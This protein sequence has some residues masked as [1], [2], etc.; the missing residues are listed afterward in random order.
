MSDKTETNY[1]PSS[2]GTGN[3]S[4]AGYTSRSKKL[5]KIQEQFEK[6]ETRYEDVLR[7]QIDLTQ[8]YQTEKPKWFDDYKDSE[9]HQNF[10][11]NHLERKKKLEI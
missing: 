2:K 9:H 7:D 6:I 8:Q 3:A 11:A 4:N 10:L 1:K 5:R